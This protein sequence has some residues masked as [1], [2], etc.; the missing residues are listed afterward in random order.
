MKTKLLFFA[1][2][3]F[4]SISLFSQ[5]GVGNTNPQASLDIS[6]SSTTTPANNDGILIPRMSNFPASPAAAQDGMLIFYTGSGASGKGFYYW[7]STT[8][9]WVF[10]ASGAKNTLDEAYDEGGA[11]NGRVINTTDGAVELRSG[12]D[13]LYIDGTSNT[14]DNKVGIEATYEATGAAILTGINQTFDS[15]SNTS[16]GRTTGI[17]QYFTNLQRA[18]SGLSN[19]FSNYSLPSGQN[20][21]GV[22][23]Y[24]N[25]GSFPFAYGFL[26]T[27]A[28]AWTINGNFVGYRNSIESGGTGYRTGFE[29]YMGGTGTG[30]KKGL[31]VN[32]ITTAGGTHYGVYSSVLKTGSY[33]GYFLGDV[34]IGTTGSNGYNLPSTDGTTNYVMA[35][36]GSGQVNFVDPS[37]LLSISHNTL[38]QAY[39]EG[40]AGNGRTITADNGA[41]SING[42]DGFVVSGSFGNGNTI[43]SEVTGAGT[44]MFFNPNQAAFRAGTVSGGQWESTS[45]GDYS[46]AFGYD[47]TAEGDYSMAFGDNTAAGASHSTAFGYSTIAEG[48]YSLAFGETTHAEGDH[49][50]AFGSNTHAEGSLSSAFGAL[51]YAY[52]TYSIAS[53]NQSQAIGDYS[54][55]VG[56]LAIAAGAYSAAFGANST[57]GGE[58]SFVFGNNSSSHADA[59]YSLVFGNSSYAQGYA[60]FA[61]GESA[62]AYANFS[63]AFGTN[64]IANNDYSIAMGRNTYAAGVNSTALGHSTIATSAYET[65]I[66]QY[67]NSLVSGNI[68]TWQSADPLFVIGNGTSSSAESNALTI[69]KNGLMNINDAYDMPLTDGTAN[70]VMATNG[71]GQVSFVDG[72]SHFWSLSGNSGTNPSTNFIGTTDNQELS[73]RVNN[74][75]HMRLTTKGQLE[76]INGS[77]SLFIGE[78]AGENDDLGDNR[79]T[80]IGYQNGF[81]SVGSQYNTSIGYQA[82]YNSNNAT[83]NMAVGNRALYFNTSGNYNTSIGFRTLYNNT[84]GSHNIGLGV[85]ALYNSQENNNNIAI[86]SYSL[87]DAN[88]GNDNIAIGFRAGDSDTTS[89]QNVYIGTESGGGDGTAESKSGNVF[90][91][92]NSGYN[93]TGDNKLYIENSSSNAPLIYG[94][95]DNNILRA[96]GELQVNNPSDSGYAFP[97]ADGTIGQLMVTD[98]SGGLTWSDAAESSTASNGLTEVGNDIRWGGALTQDT[99]ITY[100]NFDTRFN[101]NGNG[102]FIIQDAGTGKFSVLDNGDTVLGGDLYWR[103]EDTGGTILAQ[104]LDDGD[105]ARFILRENGNISVD[106][107]MNTQFVFNEQGLDRDFRIESSG[108]ANMFRIDAGENNVGIGGLPDIDLHLYHGNN[109]D[110]DGMKL[111]NINNNSWFRMYVSS[112]TDDLRFFSSNQGTTIISNINDISGAYTATSDRRLKKDF[113]NLYFSWDDFMNLQPLTYKYKADDEGKNYIGMVA[114][115]VEKIYPELITYH[116]DEDIYHMDYSATGVIAIKAVQELKEEVETLKQENTILKEKLKKLE[117]LEARILALENK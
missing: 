105:D 8:S 117:T 22:Q 59:D 91:G 90:I 45:V 31:D 112:G 7:N 81:S 88:N 41:V 34:Y 40:G 26:N 73:F 15:S 3:L 25:S 12:N 28:P 98:G 63:T 29:A 21:Y 94:E 11:G 51:T 84:I 67:N 100:G 64:T 116:E 23:N 68:T 97:T 53:G 74:N 104:M 78:Q 101:L 82:M 86:G 85:N 89:S 70:Q 6:A 66:G 79:N 48:D 10:L 106:L 27:L 18:T 87:T 54:L 108:R 92:Y 43:D 114:Q 14:T 36:D 16:P 115:D 76:M 17:I 62:N 38:D 4:Y 60:S 109:G 35:T 44:R 58:Y 110:A 20:I 47:T 19:S 32:I 52:G 77:N 99:N 56:Q 61:F 24:F 30:T 50:I 57:A 113:K 46:T 75:E 103:D 80:F 95:F 72:D 9:T 37:S 93:A 33:S 13:F 111:E 71:L 102:D 1:L 96:N 69:Y 55:T 65:V 107:D 83:C 5:V 2:T 49:S 39:D 42:E